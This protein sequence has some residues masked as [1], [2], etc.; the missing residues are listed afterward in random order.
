M[1]KLKL[2]ET[3]IETSTDKAGENSTLQ[4]KT[5]A[6]NE[7]ESCGAQTAEANLVTF[8]RQKLAQ[9]TCRYD[10]KCCFYC[11][12]PV[13]F[14]TAKVCFK[15]NMAKYCSKACRIKAWKSKHKADCEEILRLKSIT[16]VSPLRKHSLAEIATVVTTK[17]DHSY[18]LESG[19]DYYKMCVIKDK[20]VFYGIP[21]IDTSTR[22]VADVIKVLRVDGKTRKL[23]AHYYVLDMCTAKVKKLHYVIVS[24]ISGFP[25]MEMWS[26]PALSSKPVASC[27]NLFLTYDSLCYFENHL[28]VSDTLCKTITQYTLASRSFETT[29]LS[30]PVGNKGNYGGVLSLCALRQNGERRIIL[31]F[32]EQLEGVFVG[33]RRIDFSGQ[34][35][36]EMGRHRPTIVGK[37]GMYPIYLC[38]DTPGNV[39]VTDNFRVLVFNY[40]DRSLRP[41]LKTPGRVKAIEYSPETHQLYVLHANQ[42]QTRTM[43]SVYNIGEYNFTEIL[44]AL[45]SLHF[46]TYW[47]TYINWVINVLSAEPVRWLMILARSKGWI[48]KPMS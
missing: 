30:I 4:T 31:V 8:S 45:Y 44:E 6:Q 21:T 24:G 47:N 7:N 2:L 33:I 20:P 27:T 23:P 28:L 37:N 17:F 38:I 48:A 15:C 32:R 9:I 18:V 39:Y 1:Q 40:H 13:T 35:L 25:R 42:E 46:H 22:P 5:A 43:V 12:K 41:V 10:P 16:E 3:I 36:W 26:Y 34:P 11:Q 29:G 19:I 14:I